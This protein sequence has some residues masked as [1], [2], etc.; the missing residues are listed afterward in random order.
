MLA[1]LILNFLLIFCSSSSLEKLILATLPST[2]RT[3]LIKQNTFPKKLDMLAEKRLDQLLESD[4]CFPKS[5][6]SGCPEKAHM[7]PEKWFKR[8]PRKGTHTSRKGVQTA[9][10]KRHTCFPK[11]GSSGCPK[12]AHMLPE[13]W[14]KRLPQKGTHASRKMAQAAAPKSDTC[15]PKSGSSGHPEKAHILPE[16]WFKRLPK[17]VKRFSVKSRDNKKA[18][19]SVKNRD[20]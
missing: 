10:P 11:R 8:L 15:L 20:N 4:T 16:K 19:F 7:L 13:K 14:F 12:K 18:R 1:E 9:T 3:V 2:C 5:G 17:S 6:S